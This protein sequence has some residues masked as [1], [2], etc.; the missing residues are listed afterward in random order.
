MDLE[1]FGKILDFFFARKLPRTMFDGEKKTKKK[2]QL[3]NFEMDLEIF[4]NILEFFFRS[5]AP[6]YHVRW[7]KKNEIELKF[8]WG[9]E[10]IFQ[11]LLYLSLS[12]EGRQETRNKQHVWPKIFVNIFFCSKASKY[13]D[14]WRKWKKKTKKITW[15]FD[16]DLDFFFRSKAS[17]TIFEIS[18][19]KEIKTTPLKSKNP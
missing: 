18:K 19:S 14:R 5:K 4:G 10:S 1:I 12:R 7:R 16:M 17:K 3:E 9:L 6:K 2:I 11:D 15:I 8:W 13:H